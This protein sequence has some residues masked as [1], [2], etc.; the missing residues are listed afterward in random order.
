VFYPNIE[1]FQ[2]FSGYLENCISKIGTIGIFKVVPPKE[3]VARKE[4]YD[5]LKF[6]VKR[7]IE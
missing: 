3:W 2:D 6:E 1:E 7:P 4:G 5:N